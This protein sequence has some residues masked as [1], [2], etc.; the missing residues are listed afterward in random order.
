[1]YDFLDDVTSS[2]IGIGIINYN[3]HSNDNES[4][5]TY[6]L[7]YVQELEATGGC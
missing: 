2:R 6:Y 3:F 1:M 5:D 7:Y 4:I